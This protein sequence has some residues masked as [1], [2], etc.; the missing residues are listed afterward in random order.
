MHILLYE[1]KC[2]KKCISIY[3]RSLEYDQIYSGLGL[4]S[5]LKFFFLLTDTCIGITQSS[6]VRKFCPNNKFPYKSSAG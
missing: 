5:G 4:N 6:G 2:V 1:L 3:E